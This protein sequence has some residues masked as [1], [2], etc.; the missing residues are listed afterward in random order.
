MGSSDYNDF[1]FEQLQDLEF[2]AGYL[3]ECLKEGESTFLLALKDI[4]EAHGGIGN[5]AK[6]TELNREGLYK[7][8]SESGN[9]TL[10]SLYVI[11]SSLGIELQFTKKE[12]K[13]A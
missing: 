3:N 13:A 10:S 9:P 4:V 8:L 2:A 11:L 5:L 6:R 7:M 1:L 12:E